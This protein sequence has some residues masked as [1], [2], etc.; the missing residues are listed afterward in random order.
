MSKQQRRE[1]RDVRRVLG[2]YLYGLSPLIA[3]AGLIFAYLFVKAAL[4]NRELARVGVPARGRVVD[5]RERRSST[6]YS[7]PPQDRPVVRR[8]TEVVHYFPVVE[9]TAPN[10]HVVRFVSSVPD[11][12]PASLGLAVDVIHD[13]ANP[14]RAEVRAAVTPTGWWLMPPL[15]GLFL[16]VFGAAP[17]LFVWWHRRQAA[18]VTLPADG[19]GGAAGAP[20]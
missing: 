12:Q 11:R 6:S 7:G 1:N 19:T 17:P 10:G 5:V 20:R 8:S 9:F 4:D 14:R 16:F 13:P 3:L 2:L 18:A 15:F